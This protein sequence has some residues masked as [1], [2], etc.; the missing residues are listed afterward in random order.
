[1]AKKE[2][3]K[4]AVLMVSIIK[5]YTILFWTPNILVINKTFSNTGF[6]NDNI[7]V[8]LQSP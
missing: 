4:G 1:M 2:G 8:L 3:L 6:L 7:L 5:H